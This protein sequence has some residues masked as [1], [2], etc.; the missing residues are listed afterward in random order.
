MHRGE[1]FVPK[2]P[3]YRIQD[4]AK[5]IAPECEQRVIGLRPGE[6]IHEEMVTS[7]DSCN[8]LDLG[9]SYAILPAS[10]NALR[11][12]YTKLPGITEVSADFRYQS[13]ENSDFLSVEQI[14][15][16]IS[17]HVHPNYRP[18]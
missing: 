5:A 1:I 17:N 7:S 9:D 8:T 3:S 11:L 14:R 16:L 10:D 2:L 4:V 18:G 13:G 15:E 6:K 12:H